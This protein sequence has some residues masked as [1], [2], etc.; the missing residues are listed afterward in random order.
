[1]ATPRTEAAEPRAGRWHRLA[2]GLGAL[3]LAACGGA[4]AASTAHSTAGSGAA[5]AAPGAR[6]VACSVLTP[7]DAEP[8][9]GGPV[10]QDAR[11]TG[12]PAD[13]DYASLCSYSAKADAGTLLML[14]VIHHRSTSVA[15][16]DY[17]SARHMLSSARD[18]PDL[19]EAAF[20]GNLLGPTLYVLKGQFV[21][22]FDATKGAPNALRDVAARVVPRIA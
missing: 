4:G 21:I 22:T 14:H 9:L 10:D 18:V 20:A 2:A 8:F 19:G 15:R 3:A 12:V 1:M 5:P 6:V 11:E 17:S 13:A 7:A 16:T